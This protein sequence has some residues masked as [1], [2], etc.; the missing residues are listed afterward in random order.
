MT[1]GATEELSARECEIL[2]LVATGATNQQIAFNLSI[3]VNTVKTHLRNIFGKLGVESRTEATLLAV[4]LGLVAGAPQ[5]ARADVS[6]PAVPALPT[7]GWADWPLSPSQRITAILALCLVLIVAAWPRA[8][9][10]LALSQSRLVDMPH[11]NGDLLDDGNTGRWHT[12]TQMPTWRSRF[13]QA[14]QNGI[15][16]VIGGMTEA[17]WSAAVE[18]YDPIE[19]RWSVRNSK[20]T[21]VANVSAAVVDGRIYVPG[22]LDRA[23][24][25]RDILEIYDPMTDSWS[26]GASLPEA[27]CAYA[28]AE[29]EGGFYVFGGW[30]GKRHLDTVFYYDVATNSWQ[31]PATLR[32]PRSFAAAVSALGRIYV[33]GGY[34]GNA[35]FATCE[36][37]DPAMAL[38]GQDPWRSH[39]PMSVARAGHAA[40]VSRDNIYIVGGGW[41]DAVD[42]NERYDVANDAWSSFE[43]PVSGEWRALGL[44]SLTTREGSFL[45]AVGGW[46]GR[47]LGNVRAYQT[48][49]QVYLP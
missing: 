17:G 4:R 45:Y 9:A 41:D 38:K 15:I 3:S 11:T 16:Y 12:K 42:H 49:F 13:A 44:A 37:F 33:I 14:A 29:A 40:A 8:Q 39:A 46:N 30:N 31:Q 35:E 24:L 20:P 19:D 25:V 5:E 2:K 10:G 6:P 18:A 48:F 26:R 36:S 47:Y 43:T 32:A 28:I 27:L 21:A 1:A 7:L 23:S 34:D 22:G